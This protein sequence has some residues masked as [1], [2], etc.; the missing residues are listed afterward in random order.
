[1]SK[2]KMRCITCGKWF[3][4]ANAKE[5][6]CPDCTQKAR[7]EKLASKNTPP[8]GNRA[9][10]PN[11]P[12]ATSR[13]VAP[14]PK[15]KPAQSNTS[16]WFDTLDDVKVGQP[17]QPARPPKLP[18]SPASRDNSGG[19]Q[20]GYRGPGQRRED[21]QRGPG[22]YR[23]NDRGPGGY[24]E[25]GRGPG[26][27]REGGRTPGGYREGGRTPGNYRENDRGPGGYRVGGGNGLSSTLG[28]R[29]RQPVE[30]GFGRPP[31]ERGP[32]PGG[33]GGQRPKGKGKPARPAAPP[34][35]KKE[36]TPPPQPFQPTPEQV[37]QVELRYTELA[38]PSE[39]DGIRTQIAKELSIP[40]K[41]V[42]KIVKEFRDRQHI[43]S[44]WE[45]QTYKGS[46]EELEKIKAL[47][48]PFLPVPPVGVHKQLAEQL[49]FKPGEVYQ[50]IKT[51]R[52][53]MNLPQYNDPVLHEEELA[54]IREA[55]EQQKAEAAASESPDQSTEEQTPIE[56][57][58][59]VVVEQATVSTA[60]FAENSSERA[61]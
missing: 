18:T 10:G 2:I 45:V 60:P 54:L 41:A 25:G 8:P 29:P 13:P 47:Y 30:G 44:W 51:I 3:Q 17:D 38:T 40:K 5:V 49:N 20:G 7:K 57:A 4:S 48:E 12:G 59:S 26:G 42:K 39:F 11:G 1:M 27:Y 24:R 34:R 35:L 55:R 53:E 33:P 19:Q 43:P 6:T 58:A 36:K 14:P 16:H 61:E 22:G 23:E 46:S 50:A 37:A 21:Q 52:Q 15:P 28:Q 31:H 9:A 32:R 56:A